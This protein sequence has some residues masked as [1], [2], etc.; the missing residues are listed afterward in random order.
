MGEEPGAGSSPLARGLQDRRRAAA[1]A[2]GIIP[3][4]AGFTGG[5]GHR[6]G[7]G[8]DHPRSR[9]V[10]CNGL[11][12]LENAGGSSPLARGLR[13]PIHPD[14]LERRIIPARAGFTPRRRPCGAGCAD[15]P[16]SRGVYTWPLVLW[17]KSCGSSPLARGLPPSRRGRDP[18][19]RIIPARAGFTL[20][21]HRNPREPRDHPRS[22]G[23]YCEDLVHRFVRKGS[24][25][26]ARGLLLGD[27][28]D[29]KWPGIIPARAGFTEDGGV[30]GVSHGD[31]P[32][33]RGVYSSKTWM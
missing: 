17:A 19:A 3:A 23:V 6:T 12:K 20:G 18:E 1:V 21:P 13:V 26:L 33:S 9:G 30:G 15:H 8:T 27:V 4:R 24:S 25:P 29:D 32:R 14:R 28:D 5:S 31:H 2:A 22:R 7:S 11:G 16:R 10:Y